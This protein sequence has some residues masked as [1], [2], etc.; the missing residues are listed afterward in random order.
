MKVTVKVLVTQWCLALCDLL[1]HKGL[2]GYRLLC[3]LDSLGKNFGVRCHSLLQGIFQPRGWTQVSCIAGRFFIV[4]ATREAPN[5]G[6]N[7]YLQTKTSTIEIVR[8]HEIQ[9]HSRK[10]CFILTNLIK[11]ITKWNDV[12]LSTGIGFPNN[13]FKKF[14]F[15]VCFKSY[16][17]FSVCFQEK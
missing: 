11:W 3:P 2:L 5:Q 17:F 13:D 16:H 1:G 10:Y 7:K 9:K 14:L 15:K 8:V 12:A 4:W 6:V